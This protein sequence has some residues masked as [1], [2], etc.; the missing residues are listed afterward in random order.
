MNTRKIGSRYEELAAALLQRRGYQIL[1]RN[2]R[3]RIGEIDLVAREGGYLVFVEVKYRR[4]TAAGGASAAVNAQKR[5]RI[6]HA[7][8]YYIQ[9]KGLYGDEG[10]RFDVVAVDGRQIHIIR[11]AFPYA[12]SFKF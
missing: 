4:N 11:N 9:Q 1:E 10:V 2:Y 12:G 6:R 3:C 5:Q 7:A 8:E